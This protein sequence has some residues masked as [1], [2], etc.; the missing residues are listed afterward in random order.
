MLK[1]IISLKN[2]WFGIKFSFCLLSIV[3]RQKMDLNLA[4]IRKLN[5]RYRIKM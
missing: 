3:L 5:L 2:V 1:A 4:L